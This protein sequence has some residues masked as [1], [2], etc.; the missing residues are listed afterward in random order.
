[1]EGRGVFAI[2]LSCRIFPFSGQSNHRGLCSGH[3]APSSTLTDIAYSGGRGPD[4]L[5]WF[6][7]RFRTR[8]TATLYRHR[9]PVT[10]RVWTPRSKL[11]LKCVQSYRFDVCV[12]TRKQDESPL[13]FSR[14]S[15]GRSS[16]F[17]CVGLTECVIL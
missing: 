4:L 5:V 1:M 10:S 13:S 6:R 8:P 11:A 12:A 17:V 15:S 14:R 3:A 7:L 9:H 2:N 16:P